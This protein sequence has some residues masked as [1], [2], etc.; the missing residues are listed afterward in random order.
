[1]EILAGTGRLD[2]ARK[3]DW[4]YTFAT[5]FLFNQPESDVEEENG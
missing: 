2:L 1:V 5:Q 4:T 3:K